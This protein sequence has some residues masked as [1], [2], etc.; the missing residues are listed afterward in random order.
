[1]QYERFAYDTFWK[2]LLAISREEG[3]ARAEQIW[4]WAL[5]YG[6]FDDYGVRLPDVIPL[7]R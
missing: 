1:M 2:V 5:Q 4:E 7:P 3:N 6:A